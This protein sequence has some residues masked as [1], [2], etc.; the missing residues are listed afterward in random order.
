MIRRL[1][2]LLALPALLL[3]TACGGTEAGESSGD[4]GGALTCDVMNQACPAGFRCDFLAGQCVPDNT[5]T[6]DTGGPEDVVDDADTGEDVGTDIDAGQPETTPTTESNCSD[7]NDDDNDGLVDCA[8][9][10]CAEDVSCIEVCDD[11]IDNDDDGDVDCEDDD[12]F[13]EEV[14]IEVCDDEIDNDADGRTDCE[15][16]DCAEEP[17]CAEVCDD[18]LDNNFNGLTDCAEP[19]CAVTPGCPETLCA[20]GIDNNNDGNIDCEEASCSDSFPCGPEGDEFTCDDNIDNDGDGDRD[21]DDS[22]CDRTIVCAGNYV[23]WVSYEISNPL[24]TLRLRPIDGSAGGIDVDA[25]PIPFDTITRF[26]SFSSDGTRLAYAYASASGTPT[27]DR[28]DVV[29]VRV[30]DLT[31]GSATD[32]A[33][34]GLRRH[35]YPSF[36]ADGEFITFAAEADVGSTVAV[37]IYTVNLSTGTV[38]EPLTGITESN[39]SAEDA[40]AAQSPLFTPDGTKIYYLFGVPGDAEAGAGFEIWRMNPDGSEQEAVTENESPIGTISMNVEGTQLTYRS[41]L[42]GIR[43]LDIVEPAPGAGL[44][45]SR[46]IVSGDTVNGPR[47]VGIGNRI[48]FSRRED[49]SA[50]DLFVVDVNT[51]VETNMTNTPSTGE[52]GAWP[53]PVPVDAF[54]LRLTD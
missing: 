50:S 3:L 33:D 7:G 47:F 31:T 36:S 9:D 19:S 48:I 41:Q 38:S 39:P 28:D 32:F 25:S 14:C 51:G 5:T 17:R 49:S 23:G 35:F 29:S 6:E 53:S 13:G 27:D 26:G 20:D 10:D 4:T 45:P 54:P 16:F 24:P 40:L 44:S 15:D 2:P 52:G 42:G 12:C 22:D 43:I 11:E 21:C 30:R 8:D 46:V 34:E 37:N 1:S 18:G